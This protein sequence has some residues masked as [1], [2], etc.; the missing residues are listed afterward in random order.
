[1]SLNDDSESN[2]REGIQNLELLT[3]LRETA[4]RK[5]EVVLV[6]LDC[7]IFHV[8]SFCCLKYGTWCCECFHKHLVWLCCHGTWWEPGKKL[9][10]NLSLRN[11]KIFRGIWC[12][13]CRHI[14]P[15][16]HD[17]D[18]NKTYHTSEIFGMD[19]TLKGGRRSMRWR[20]CERC[21]VKMSLTASSF[22]ANLS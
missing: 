16:W 21:F 13:D 2:V 11:G 15:S 9:I 12:H 19:Q 14:A 1:M 22:R 8:L 5:V 17:I 7:G 4:W 18:S 10:R 3:D 6:W 20:S